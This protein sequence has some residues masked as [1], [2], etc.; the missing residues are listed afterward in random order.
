MKLN[1]N[2]LK[3]FYTEDVASHGVPISVP[4]AVQKNFYKCTESLGLLYGWI[5]TF[6]DRKPKGFSTCKSVTQ[7]SLNCYLSYPRIF[8]TNYP[9]SI[10]LAARPGHSLDGIS[11]LSFS[12]SNW[13][14]A[15]AFGT[16]SCR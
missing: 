4:L 2:Y 11:L 10:K 6:T 9:E 14:A 7:S 3:K 1:S 8:L 13:P 12:T 15:R 16:V 5:A